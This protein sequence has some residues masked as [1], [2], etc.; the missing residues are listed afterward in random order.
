[1]NIHVPA[2]PQFACQVRRRMSHRNGVFVVNKLEQTGLVGQKG[3]PCVRRGL[4]S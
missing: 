4:A 1:M 2:H 3:G